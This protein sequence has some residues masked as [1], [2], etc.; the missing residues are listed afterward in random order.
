MPSRSSSM[1]LAG[2]DG[3]DSPATSPT[4]HHKGD[5]MP[6]LDDV[7][8]AV[9]EAI[10][11]NSERIVALGEQIRRNPELGFKEFKTARVVEQTLGQLGFKPRTGLALTGVR[12]EVKGAK[13]G[14][15][16]ALLGELDGLVVAGHPVADPATGAAHACGH[17]AQVAGLLGAAMGLAG[18]KA[19]EHLAGRVVFFAVP[20]E[21]YGDVAW[22]VEQARAGKLEFLGGKPELLRLGHFDDVDMAMMIHLTP[23]KEYRRAGV[24]ASNNG[25]IVKTVRYIGRASHAGGAPHL[26]INAL[27]AAQIGLSSINAIR[28]TFRDEDSIRVHPIITHGGSQVNVIPGEV[29]I[30]TYVRGKSVEAILDANVRVDRALKAGALALGAQVEIETLPGYLP[31]FNHDGMSQ[32]FVANASAH[33]GADNVT[34]MGHRS[35][36]TDMGDISHIMP[37]LHPYIS[38]AAGSGH[39]ADYR[40][41]DPKLAYVENAKQLALMAVDMLWDG[42]KAAKGIIA[43]FKPR[44]SKD[45]YLSFQRG[46]NKTELFDGA[47]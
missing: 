27:Y 2:R 46:I 37:T 32:Y 4:T 28:V 15:T 14:P 20:A 41:T 10:D 44:L 16:F 11:R 45:A 38:G 5:V 26:G 23:Q 29:R 30:E 31:L 6:T 40:I 9:C 33:L 34:Q 24:A 3:L 7:K 35:G 43:E 8:R 18:A 19:F 42:A 13:D 47:K 39:G 36:S 22:R 21:E 17:N 1:P 25:C 12:A